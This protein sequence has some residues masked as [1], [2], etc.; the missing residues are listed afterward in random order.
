VTCNVFVPFL[1]GFD[2]LTLYIDEKFMYVKRRD[3]RHPQMNK[4]FPTAGLRGEA[5]ISSDG[6]FLQLKN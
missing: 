2:V 3:S 5:Q 1:W 6:L 4:G